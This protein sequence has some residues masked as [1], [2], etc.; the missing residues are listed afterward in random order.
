MLSFRPGSNIGL[1]LNNLR[2]SKHWVP[3]LIL[4]TFE[5]RNDSLIAG[6]SVFCHNYAVKPI[7]IV[8]G[9]SGCGKTTLAQVLAGKS[10][11]HCF[12]ADDFHPPA[13]KAKMAAGIPL[14]D[15]DRW[16][17]LDILHAELQAIAAREESVFLA[18]SALKQS[19]RDRLVQG[20]MQARFVYL[21][22]SFE[23]I[24][25]RLLARRNHFMPAGLLE[26]Q[27][28]ILEEPGD[29]II[30]DASHSISQLVDDF[31]K[32]TTTFS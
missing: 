8:M 28:A 1:K 14:T 11:A 21:R 5:S 2:Y 29:A 10:G 30:L 31:Q 6:D 13:N 26:S 16:P 7:F 27:F 4:W 20:L 32:A 22:G 9:V 15:A 23:V 3:R 17:W 24:Q 19:Y 25:A 18:C 12:D